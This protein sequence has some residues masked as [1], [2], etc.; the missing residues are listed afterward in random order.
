VTVQTPVPGLGPGE[1]SLQ[2]FRETLD[3]MKRQAEEHLHTNFHPKWF[4]SRWQYEMLT[5]NWPELTGILT[6]FESVP[7]DMIGWPNP[8]PKSWKKNHGRARNRRR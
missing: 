7:V 6:I 2:S 8:A 4:V 1:F 3:H 5:G